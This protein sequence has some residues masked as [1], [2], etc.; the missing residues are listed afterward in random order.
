TFVPP[1]PAVEVSDTPG[2]APVYPISLDLPRF[3]DLWALHRFT[4]AHSVVVYRDELF[5]PNFYGNSFVSEPVGNLVH[6][7]VLHRDGVLFHSSRSADEQKSEFLASFDGWFRP[8][9]LRVG[10]DGALW[11]CDMY[12]MVIEH[13]EWI[14]RE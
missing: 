14:P 12:R 11:V 13:P 6:R 8:T 2:T 9:M 3:N 7:E 4:S 1:K 10:P 5:G